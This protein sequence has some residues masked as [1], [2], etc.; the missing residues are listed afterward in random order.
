M[1]NDSFI[2][3]VLSSIDLINFYILKLKLPELKENMIILISN[4]VGGDDKS[5]R[6][7]LSTEIYEDILNI[8]KE[9]SKFCVFQIC[10]EFLIILFQYS[11]R[12]EMSDYFVSKNERIFETSLI[13]KTLVTNTND[14]IIL[15]KT[16]ECLV[17]FTHK[18]PIHNR[19]FL[20][21]EFI[22]Y[23]FHYLQHLKK[24]Y[25]LKII[26]NLT[27]GNNLIIFVKDI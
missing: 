14:D 6:V 15:S 7:I 24:N 13:L 8:M 3:D 5:R 11:T 20:N 27:S 21:K 2:F 1:N 19:F 18:F 22:D 23:L 25:T 26:G 12:Q 9:E 10:M 4:L 17:H 16:L